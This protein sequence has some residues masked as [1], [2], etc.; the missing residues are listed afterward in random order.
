[1]ADSVDGFHRAVAQAISP[2]LAGSGPSILLVPYW[3]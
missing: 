3:Q 2:I 1:M